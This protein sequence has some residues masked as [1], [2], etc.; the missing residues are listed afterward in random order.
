MLERLPLEIVSKVMGHHSPDFTDKRYLSL[1]VGWLDRAASR[2]MDRVALAAVR[3]SEGRHQPS[4]TRRAAPVV[5]RLSG[6][7]PC[8]GPRHAACRTDGTS[9]SVP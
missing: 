7:A 9:G 6:R 5:C 1:R 8:S 3:A 4:Q 2:N